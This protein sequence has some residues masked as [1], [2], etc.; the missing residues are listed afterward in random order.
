MFWKR[1]NYFYDIKHKLSFH[2]LSILELNLHLNFTFVFLNDS[3][4]NIETGEDNSFPH[5]ILSDLDFLLSLSNYNHLSLESGPYQA[6][7]HLCF[8]CLTHILTPW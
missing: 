2:G 5:G 8:S 1:I 7:H 3:L 6:R 4:L